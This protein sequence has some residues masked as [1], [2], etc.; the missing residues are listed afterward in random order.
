MTAWFQGSVH[1]HDSQIRA[2]VR[3]SFPSLKDVN[4]VVQE[5]YLRAWKARLKHPI[6]N[7]K[8][9]LF[10]IVRHVALDLVRRE[11]VSPVKPV[12]NLA[13]LPILDNRRAVVESV[14]EHEKLAMVA[15]A[16]QRLPARCQ[17]V[18]MQRKLKNRSREEVAAELRISEKTVDEH[19]ARGI[20]K[21]EKLLR[22]RGAED[23]FRRES[24][25]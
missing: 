11:R 15:D 5:S 7:A 6:H 24:G 12:G 1:V 20:R 16:M 2:Y 4:D 25:S 21:L 3:S 8:G 14:S 19:L 18:V 9:F 22:Q 23:F 13:T 10:E 17:E